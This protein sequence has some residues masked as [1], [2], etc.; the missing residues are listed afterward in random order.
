MAEEALSLELETPLAG[1]HGYLWLTLEGDRTQWSLGFVLTPEPG[2]RGLEGHWEAGATAAFTAA[3]GALS[4]IPVE[5][6]PVETDELRT[7]EPSA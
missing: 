7:W 3:L 4:L 2:L 5:P 6:A 1:G